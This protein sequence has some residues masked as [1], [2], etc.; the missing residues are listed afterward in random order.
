MKV[1]LGGTCNDSQWRSQL[2]PHLNCE[3]FNPVVDDWTPECQEEELRQ[4]KSCDYVLY[5]ITPA[6]V[7]TY[8]IAEAVDDSNK[9]PSQTIFC[10]LSNDTVGINKY[11]FGKAQLKSLEAVSKLI[12]ANGGLVY[13]NL[14]D[15]ASL[16]NGL[17]KDQS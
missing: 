10:Y 11:S 1:F 15:V 12:Q 8:S 5:V 16:L 9:R 7:G 3:Y 4:R 17:H 14:A 6:M 2:I 13:T